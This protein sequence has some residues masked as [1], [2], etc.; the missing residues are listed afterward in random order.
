MYLDIIIGITLRCSTLKLSRVRTPSSEEQLKSGINCK[1][2]SKVQA[3]S[4]ITL[5]S[6]FKIFIKFD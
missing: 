2:G 4:E 6:I 1:G 3:V 5:N